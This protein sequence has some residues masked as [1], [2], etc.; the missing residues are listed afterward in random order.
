MRHGLASGMLWGLSTVIVACALNLPPLSAG[1]AIAV[2][3]TAAFLHDA[4][5]ATWLTLLMV[6]KRRLGET[7]SALR[8]RAGAKVVT[9]ALLGGPVGTA[10]YVTAIAFLGPGKTA[11]ISGFYPAFGALAAR[12]LLKERMSAWQWAFLGLAIIGVSTMGALAAHGTSASPTAWW[13]LAGGAACVVGW[14]SEAV[15]SA[16]AMREDALDNALALHIREMTSALAFALV[17]VPVCRA[18]PTVTTTATSTGGLI[19][20]G[21]AFVGTAS[22]LC[23]YR[24][25]GLIGAARATALNITYTVWA[26]IFG[27]ALTHSHPTLGELICCLAVLVG[28]VGASQRWRE[29]VAPPPRS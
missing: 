9:A 1:G 21:A 12:V 10:G 19:L 5:C 7:W 3:I 23:Y 25:I 4:A 22:Y 16:W 18:W 6:S 2:A 13:G 24:A 20:A 29:L 11:I 14:G 26:L 8:S 17:L 15:L 28:S 27:V